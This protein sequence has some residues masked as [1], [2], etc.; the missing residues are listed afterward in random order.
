[1]ASPTE[2]AA[3]FATAATPTLAEVGYYPGLP[4][5]NVGLHPALGYDLYPSLRSRFAGF[6]YSTPFVPEGTFTVEEARLDAL[7]VWAKKNQERE[8][9]RLET[10]GELEGYIVSRAQHEAE[11]WEKA[12]LLLALQRQ[13]AE[14]ELVKARDRTL[15]ER[16]ARKA[17]ADAERAEHERDITADPLKR[18]A[19]SEALRAAAEVELVKCQYKKLELE[20]KKLEWEISLVGAM[21]ETTKAERAKFDAERGK[22]DAEKA[23]ADADK[24]RVDAE[25]A[26][27]DAEKLRTDAETAKINAERVKA[28]AETQRAQAQT[29]LAHAQAEAAEAAAE[30]ALHAPPPPGEMTQIIDQ[31]TVMDPCVQGF[32]WQDSPKE[33]GFRCTG[34]KHFRSYADARKFIK[35]R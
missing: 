22:A 20:K 13:I 19:E 27:A 34:G 9:A 8:E 25:R 18:K 15:D 12:L 1:M 5:A 32:P 35:R 16:L 28:D 26:R 2:N 17:L 7:K 30:A 4:V 33:G 29:V 21:V 6:G 23:C 11:F 14:A 10:E 24:L 31:L 3:Y